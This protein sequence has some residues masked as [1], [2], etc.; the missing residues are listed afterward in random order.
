M[1]LFFPV[2]RPRTGLALS[3]QAISLV[4]LKPR[5]LG[6][7]VRTVATQP[8]SDGWLKPDAGSVNI[9]DMPEMVK[10]LRELLRATRQRT[11]AISLPLASAHVALFGF[12]TLSAREEDRLAVLRWRFQQDEHVH[13][14]DA[15]LTY[16]LCGTGESQP[17]DK[18][19]TSVLAVAIKRQILEQYEALCAQAGVI[20][21]SIGWSPL[22]LFELSRSSIPKT[23]EVFLVHRGPEAMVLLALRQ[24]VPQFLRIKPGRLSMAAVRGEITRSLQYYDDLYSHQA[25]GEPATPVPLYI[26]MEEDDRETGLPEGPQPQK[27][28]PDLLYPLGSLSWSVQIVRPAWPALNGV[29][30]KLTSLQD[31]SAFAGAMVG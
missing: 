16:R 9:R 4:E 24:G 28:E 15:A 19:L 5:W 2:H 30:G 18:P 7:A 20:P 3:E 25:T 23:E 14:A 10:A 26:I 31:W 8:L 11:L 29:Q 1:G 12:E 21:A 17:G 27:S 22:Q 6:R 13:V